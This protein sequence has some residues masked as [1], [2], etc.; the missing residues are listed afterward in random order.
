MLRLAFYGDD[1][2]GSTDVM[3]VL[4]LAGVPTVLF[5][6]PP[7]PDDLA[8]HPGIGAAG[9]AGI[10]RSLPTEAM[11]AELRPVFEALKT[12]GAPLVHYKVCS[13]FDSSPTVGSIGRAIEVGQSVFSPLYVPVVVGAPKLGRFVVFGNLFA[14]GSSDLPTVV[15][16]LDEHPT[17]SRH[18]VTPMKEADLLAHL[19][20]QIIEAMCR[21]NVLMLEGVAGSPERHLFLLQKCGANII[22]FDTL[23]DD[24]LR[25]VGRLIWQE[26]QK[27]GTPLFSASSSGLEY[28]L[29]AHWRQTGE[30]PPTPPTFSPAPVEQVVVVSGSCSPITD[31]QIHASV[32]EARFAEIALDTKRIT[33]SV[34]DALQEQA[35]TLDAALSA[36]LSGRPGVVIHTSRGPDD[37]R[38]AAS[39]R[40]TGAVLGGALGRILR[41][42]LE[43]TGLRRAVVCGGDTSSYVAR[44]LGIAALTMA[45]PMAAGS[46]LCRL[47]AEDTSSPIDGMEMV[48]KGGQVGNVNL[49]DRVRQGTP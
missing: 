34:A 23:T 22:L 24:H 39:A 13:T 35:R 41:Q 26:V 47:H 16:R 10:S 37:P 4:T 33:G 46:P 48:F 6:R 40:A 20:E 43:K 14:R 9:V 42:I 38:I 3:E 7:T 17:M 5:L 29:T 32:T 8:R 28:A 11:E 31:E 45:G 15:Y 36:L 21:M 18:P 12:L 1:F 49:F 30:L 19:S 27:S 44:E 2:T 25:V